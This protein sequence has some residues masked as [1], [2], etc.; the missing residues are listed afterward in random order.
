MIKLLKIE[1]AKL[2]SYRTFWVLIGIYFVFLGIVTMSGMEALT[3][4]AEKGAKIDGFDVEKVPLYHFPDIWQNLTYVAQYFKLLLGIFI[5]ISITNEFSYKTIRQN[6]IDG[7]SRAEFIAS[8]V[9]FI[10]GISIVSTV[11]VLLIG[12]LMGSIYSPEAEMAYMFKHINFNLAFFLATFNY[13]LLVMVIAL[14]VKRAGLAIV[15]LL[16][17]PA[18]ELF[19]T[20][21][22]PTS[23]EYLTEYLPYSALSNLIDIPFPKYVFM[24]IR[25]A[26][27]WKDVLINIIYIPI[28]IGLGYNSIAKRNLS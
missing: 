22:L 4:L 13:L 6:V 20:I 21:P 7:M 10:L 12:L 27:E 14:I 26:V 18:F 24:E 28:L 11:F 19:L 15:I 25:D 3:W 5:I 9:L 17:Y 1:L 23:L 8:K 16:V 2:N